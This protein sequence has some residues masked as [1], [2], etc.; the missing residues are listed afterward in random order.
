MAFSAA[1]GLLTFSPFP[2]DRAAQVLRL[3]LRLTTTADE[4]P[5]AIAAFATDV[6]L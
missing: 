6:G 4:V 2:A 1:F 3:S 5:A